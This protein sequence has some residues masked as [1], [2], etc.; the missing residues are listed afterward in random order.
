MMVDMSHVSAE[1]M[2]DALDVTKAPVIFSHS[3]AHGRVPI[4]R[5]MCRTMCSS[6]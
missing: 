1:T 4:I 5:A 6:G 3:S 2:H